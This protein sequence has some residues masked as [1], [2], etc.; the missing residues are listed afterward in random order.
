MKTWYLIHNAT[1]PESVALI[2]SMAG[3]FAPLLPVATLSGRDFTE[4]FLRP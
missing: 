3:L 1:E 2:A 4:F